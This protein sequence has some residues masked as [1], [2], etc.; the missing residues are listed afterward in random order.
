MTVLTFP[1]SVRVA[2]MVQWGPVANTQ[3]IT[4]PFDSSTQTVANPGQR[5]KASVSWPR[6]PRA[7]WPVL[8]AF[9]SYLGGRA[10]RFTFG[11]PQGGRR[12]TAAI[13][14]TVRVKGAGQTGSTLAIDGLP[15]SV[16]V[17]EAGDWI[18]FLNPSSRPQLHQVVNQA[19]SNGSGEVTL[20]ITPPLRGSP[21]DN[22]EV[23][24]SAPVGVFM[25]MD[26]EQGAG[27]HD[28]NRP[29]RADFSIE[30]IEALT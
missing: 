8:A 20:T 7:Q 12:A 15:N 5:W 28:A 2:A 23:N 30:I 17:F 16:V 29:G 14:G 1:A 9:L 11:P 26:D 3:T 6:L 4:S 25:L 24:W 19:T 10:G 27:V 21:A 22:V 13:G 18:S